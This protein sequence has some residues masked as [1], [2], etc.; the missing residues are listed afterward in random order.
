MITCSRNLFR[1][2]KN[3]YQTK[4][5]KRM[6]W[7]DFL[8]KKNY[9]SFSQKKSKYSLFIF[10]F[11]ICAN[12]QFLFYF[13][14][15]TC[16]FEC[17]QSHCHILKEL[18]EFLWMMSAI[19]IFEESSFIFSFVS[20]VW[21]GD[22]VTWGWVHIWGGGRENKMS[23][24][25]CES[26]YKKTRMNHLSPRLVSRRQNPLKLSFYSIMILNTISMP[27]KAGPTKIDEAKGKQEK[28]SRQYL[29]YFSNKIH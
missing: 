2:L 16:V 10:I 28:K 5:N 24:D 11:H 9:W 1:H 4:T 22:K 18:Y 15:V 27:C 21:I 8:L 19:I 12:F 20:H 26:L 25:K 14:V 29:L 7:H 3:W 17:F 13:L 23:K 6:L